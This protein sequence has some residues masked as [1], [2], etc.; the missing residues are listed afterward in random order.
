M[1]MINRE[2]RLNRGLFP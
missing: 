1:K 2:P